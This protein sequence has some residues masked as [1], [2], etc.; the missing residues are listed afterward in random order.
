ME[1][2]LQPWERQPGET[3]RQYEAF[4]AYRNLGPRRSLVKAYSA[5]NPG[6]RLPRKWHTWS[7]GLSWVQR[8]EAYDRQEEALD[9][10]A[11]E[12]KRRC[13]AVCS[14][15]PSVSSSLAIPKSSS[16]A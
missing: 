11:R 13:V 15:V 5:L 9:R 7:S 14:F 8:A 10:A 12:T 3:S 6:G 4:C 16:R 1:D 2:Y